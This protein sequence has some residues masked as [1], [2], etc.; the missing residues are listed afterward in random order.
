[1]ENKFPNLLSLLKTKKVIII[2]TVFLSAL[3]VQAQLQS[4]LP[5]DAYGVWDRSAI[6]LDD[7]S[8]LHLFNGL[9]LGYNWSD[10]EPVN[11]NY[12]WSALDAEIQFAYDND[13]YAYLSVNPGPDCPDWVYN[14]VPK[15]LT[16]LT[17]WNGEFPY[18]LHQ[19]Y[20]THY[21]DMISDLA[22]HIASLDSGLREKIAF[23]QV[24]TGCTGDECP[25]HGT[26]LQDS[27]YKLHIN[28]TEW[29]DFRIAAFQH[30]KEVFVDAGLDIALM[31]NNLDSDKSV[32][33]AAW[34]WVSENIGTGFG[35]K[36]SAYVRGHHLT[37]ENYFK[38]KWY[39]NLV[40]PTTLPLFSRAE[41]DQSHTRPLYTINRPLGFY[42]GVL[43]G[44]NTGLSVF[45][46]TK[47]A[48][49]VLSDYPDI[50]P[51][52]EFFNRFAPEIYPATTKGA[53]SIF[54]EGLDS[55]DVVK[56]PVSKYGKASKQEIP[57][58]V[59]ICNDPVYA[60]RGA[61]MDDPEKAVKGQ[62]DQRRNQTGYNDAGWGIHPGNYERWIEQIDPDG[63]SIGL[64]RLNANSE[65]LLDENNSKYDRFARS[66]ETAT[67]KNTMYFKFHED[68]F[69]ETA[70]LPNV[71]TFELTW[72]DKHAN[73]TWELQYD[74]GAGNI[75]T[76][77]TATGTGDNQ[78]KTITVTLT[79][80]VMKNN[81]PNGADFMLVNTDDIDDIFHGFEASISR[82]EA[83]LNIGNI[84][85]SSNGK[86]KLYPN[87]VNDVL[88][89]S[90]EESIVGPKSISIYNM[91]GTLIYRVETNK[92]N[93]QID[94][95]A[96]GTKGV[97]MIKIDSQN[98]VSSHKV[99]VN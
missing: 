33:L 74:A 66:F 76:A 4:A 98:A 29:Q 97:L 16:D 64:F 88:N 2:L 18:Y 31:F 87:P 34:T 81:C 40:N 68:V 9:Q 39:D 70:G 96:L 43:S 57:R 14:T 7:D 22:A 27:P 32:E 8:Y 23:L 19:D 75:K 42:W 83:T 24:K 53:Y 93:G 99:V 20:I 79:D 15:M 38:N 35:I 85:V 94:M 51:S 13:L 58:Y 67:G 89:V 65:G 12:D 54:H 63:T 25:E 86:V 84:D 77:H 11:D 17:K 48:I 55:E 28:D 60:A 47:S 30:H 92:S 52:L 78:W 41:M 69:S 5:L 37:W 10:I 71:I 50:I 95:N 21:Y 62:V 45:D 91:L 72:L 3:N 6:S 61:Q 49:D 73:S 46:V 36:G 59:N 56:F 90:F 1:M 82:K 44:L 80:A 26:Y